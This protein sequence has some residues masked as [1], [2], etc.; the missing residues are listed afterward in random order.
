M[1]V[2]SLVEA[3]TSH[4]ILKAIE[5]LLLP[6]DDVLTQAFMTDTVIIRRDS[7]LNPSK[8][9]DDKLEL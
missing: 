2:L 4:S 3:V 6:K 8:S 5:T 9:G 7:E 1:V